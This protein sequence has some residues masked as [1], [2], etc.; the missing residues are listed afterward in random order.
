MDFNE[1]I[2]CKVLGC[3]CKKLIR[4]VQMRLHVWWHIMHDLTP[5]PNPNPNSITLTVILKFPKDSLF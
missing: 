5:N 3:K 1:K 4:L 2:K